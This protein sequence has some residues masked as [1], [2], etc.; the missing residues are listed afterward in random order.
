MRQDAVPPM[1]PF[2]LRGP[3]VR[4]LTAAA[5]ML[6]CWPAYAQAQ[7]PGPAVALQG[8]EELF[9]AGCAGC[10]GPNGA[11]MP[12]STIG[13]EKPSTF[14][15]FTQC[16]QTTPELG[17]DWWSVIHE[18]GAARGFSRIMPSFGELL[19][20]R[21]I[22]ALV[23]YLRS[24]CTDRSWPLGELNLPRP[25]NTEKAF[26][27]DETVVTASVAT[28]GAHDVTTEVAYEHRI[29]VRNQLELSIPL[30][31]MHDPSGAP[32]A[33]IG[34]VGLGLKRVLFASMQTGSIA[35]V[36][37]EIIVPTGN[38]DCGLGTGVPVFEAFGAFGQLFPAESFVQAQLGT[39]LPVDTADTPRSVFARIAAGKSWRGRQQLRPALD[40]DDRTAERTRSRTRRSDQLRSRPTDADHAQPPATRARERRRAGSRQSHSG[41]AHRVVVLCA[42]GLVRRRSVR[43][44]EMKSGAAVLGVALVTLW[45][46][47]AG[48]RAQ[49]QQGVANPAHSAGV[50]AFQTSDRCL[51]CHNGLQTPSG[52]DVSIGFDWRASIMANSS[53]DPYWQASIRRETIDH[54]EAKGAIE[55]ICST[56]HMPIAR[57]TASIHGARGQVFAHLPFPAHDAS[58]Q[59]GRGRRL[60]FAVPPDRH[61]R[62]RHAGVL[63]RSFRDRP[64]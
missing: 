50:P 60:V 62:A 23:K 53:R 24:L 8:G 20:A 3:A 55:D 14:P 10:H 38:K 16:D 9:R 29:G 57:Y 44:V 52:E 30:A 54:A 6:L 56:C 43:G 58:A 17:A 49:P 61:H 42:V 13:F 64:A 21:Q 15:D 5:L 11:G 7:A 27:E 47:A 28:Q 40:A 12:E 1:L 2:V 45:S 22:D 35:S 51:A 59:A 33:G 46:V 32:Q 4:A 26:P 37:G 34:D 19:T 39:D 25:L 48:V 31:V 36:Q 63:H 18:G 41:T